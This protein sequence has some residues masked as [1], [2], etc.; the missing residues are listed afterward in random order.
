[1]P[2]ESMN[3]TR[4]GSDRIWRGLPPRTG[5]SV[6]AAILGLILFGLTLHAGAE[7]RKVDRSLA[8]LSVEELVNLSVTS[9]SKRKQ[10]VSEAPAAIHV[11]TGE[12]IRRSGATSLPEALRMAPGLD[13]ARVDLDGWS[14]SA[15]GFNSFFANK[16]LVLIDGRSVY[17]PL[18]SGVNWDVQNVMLEDIERIE[19]IRGPGATLW[20]TNAVNGVINVITKR[21]R[22]SQGTLISAGTGSQD[23]ALV[24]A[25]QGGTLGEDGHYR[26]YAMTAGRRATREGLTAELRDEELDLGQTGFR[27]DFAPSSI[28]LFTLQ[29]DLYRAKEAEVATVR[30]AVPPFERQVKSERTAQGRNLL[31]RWTRS[32][33]PTSEIQ[34]QAYYDHTERDETAL[35][36]RRDV[37]DVDFQH[38]FSPLRGHSVIY[39]LGYNFSRDRAVASREVG[40]FR[41]TPPGR[42]LNHY[43]LFVQDDVTLVPDTLQISVGTKVERTPFTGI[44]VQPSAKL[45]YTPDRAQ[46]VWASVAR[47]VRTPSR[48]END[49]TLFLFPV[50]PVAGVP[51]IAAALGSERFDSENLLAYEVGYRTTLSP[52]L[53]LDIAAY[54]NRY[55]DL[56]TLEPGSPFPD[57]D[58][59]PRIITPF[60]ALNFADGRTFGGEVSAEW[61]IADGLRFVAG[62]S[63]VDI[64]VSLDEESAPLTAALNK[65]VHEALTP[66]H[67]GFV[68]SLADLPYGF[69][70]D[71]MVRYVGNRSSVSLGNQPG[72]E[73]D[74]YFQA[75]VRLGWRP[76]KSLEFSILGQDLLRSGTVETIANDFLSIT[77]N[78][79]ERRV[80]GKVIWR[81]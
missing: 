70:L 49:I 30:D 73:I 26:A 36:Y 75:D 1:M 65:Q 21:G 5:L 80:F 63:R 27:S 40:L 79:S 20:G 13:V 43:N 54:Y 53:S 44:E 77:P 33:S 47:A 31:G 39:G 29:G 9:V 32:F 37:G 72:I 19:V 24:S 81:F 64:S 4:V 12:D 17:T 22:D 62:Y 57:P 58:G 28:D 11:I 46:T 2:R 56:R 18:F 45:V 7:P 60:Y 16:L 25:R 3:K 35:L 8:D 68:R 6:R 55:T 41:F 51:N 34:L 10:K 59:D 50:E 15:R 38:R 71:T 42:D 67:Q 74:E 78:E 69:E 48:A 52:R 76:S 14:I 61:K 66:G 23:R